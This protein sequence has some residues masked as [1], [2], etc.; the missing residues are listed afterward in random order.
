MFDKRI[1]PSD[2]RLQKESHPE[3]TDLGVSFC[4]S[5]YKIIPYVYLVL[6]INQ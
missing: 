3:A 1:K 2:Y 6:N 5:D 4:Q